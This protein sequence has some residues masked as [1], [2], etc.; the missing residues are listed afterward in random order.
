M[1]SRRSK[2]DDWDSGSSNS[3]VNAVKNH[4]SVD[5][6]SPAIVLDEDCALSK[7]LSSSLMGRI[8][9]FASLTNLKNALMNEGFVDLNL[10]VLEIRQASFDINPD[11]RIVWVEIEGVPLKL[12]TLNTFKRIVTRW[13]N[14][15]DTNDSDG[16]LYWIRA[17]EVPGWTPDLVEDSDE[18]ELSDDDSLEEGMKNLESENDCSNSFEV[19]DT[20]FE[21]EGG[22]KKD[23]SVDPFGLYPLLNKKTKDQKHKESG[24]NSSPKFPP[25]FTPNNDNDDTGD[26][27][28]VNDFEEEKL[29]ED[30]GDS[31]NSNLKENVDESA[32]FGRF[33]KSVAPSLAQKAKKD[34]AKELCVKNKVNFLAIQ[35]TKME[36][37]DL[38][39]VRRCWG[40]STF[41]HL[42]SNSWQGEVV[43]MGDFNEVRVKS[44]RFGTNF[45]VLGANIFNSFINS[46]GLE[47][48]HLG[49]SAFTCRNHFG[50]DSL[51]I[52]I[53]RF[54]FESPA[55]DYGPV[56][57]R[58]FHH[59]IHLEGFNDFVTSTWNSAPS[60]D[61]NGMRNLAGKLK[62]LKA[63]IKI[64]IKDNKSETVSTIANL[65]KELNQLDAV[66]DK[67]TGTEVEAEKRMEVLAALRNIDHIH[68]M[69]LAQKAKIK[70]SI[71][72]DENS[73]FFHG[74]LNKKRNQMNIRGIT[75]DGVW[76]EQPNDVKQEFL[77]H[78]QDRFAKPSE[79]RANIDMRFPKTISEDQSQDLEREV[80]KQEIKT[81]VWGCGTDKSPGP[82]GFS[83]GFYRHFWP[84][85]EHDVY[86]AVNHF[87]IHGEIPP[88]CN[89]SFIALI[90]KV[91]DANLVKDFRPI[92]LI[93]SIY[94]I[95]AKIL[96]NRLV[97]VLG[98]I[99]NEVQS[100]FIA[101]RQML[102]GPFILNEILQWC[103]KK[104]KKTLIF[105]VDFEKAFDSIRWDFLDDV[106]KEFGFRCKWRNWIQSCL[107]SSKGSIL[108]NGCPTNEFQF[109]KGLKQGDPLSPFLFILVMESLHLSFQRIV[110]AGMF[111]G[112]VL[113]QSLCL[114]HMFYAD[115]AIFLGEWSDGNIST[116]IHVLKCFF[117]ASGL[118][119][120]LNKS[121]IMGINVESAQVIQAAAKLGCLVLK[122]PFYYLGTRVGGSMTR[123]QAWQEIV[124]KV[125]SRLSK[126]K[127]KTL[128]I[129]GRLTLLKS[130]LGS[131]PVFH[132]SI[133]KVPSKVLHILESIRSHFFNGHDPGS[134]KA[135]WVKWNNVLTDKKRG[136]L[137]VSSLFA[138][139][140]GLMIKWVWKFLSQKDSLWTKVIVAIHGVGGKIHSE[141]TST[142]KS[143]WLSI[144]SEVRSL[145]RK[146]MYVF[147]Y[148][149]HK[150]GNGESTKF[151]L[152]HWHTRGIFKDIFPRLYA[153]ES[154]KDVTVS[155]KIGDTSLVC[156]FRRIPRGG[157]EQNQFDS[158]VEL[159][160]S[161]TIVPS[162]DR[163]NWNL[164]STGI[165]SVASARRRIDEICLPNIGEETRWVKCVPIKIN[166]LAWKIKTDAL[167]T[168]FNISRRGIDIQDMSC[169]IC[170]NAIESTDHLFFRCGLVRDIANKVLSWWNLD[171]ANL[172]SYAEWKSWLVSI[173]MDSKLKK[174]FEGVWY[175]IWW[176]VWI[177]R[178]KLLFDERKPSKSMLIDNVIASSFYW[179][180]YRSKASFGWNE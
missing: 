124:E 73:N 18:E 87:F 52:T 119:I 83:F 136:G 43:I 96:S 160:R 68:S 19:P 6:D 38:F 65:K 148:L 122:C 90:P 151:W 78:F 176:Y 159:V 88:G 25:G 67:G 134:K 127:S 172:N 125:K 74:I 4:K 170:D 58:F 110:N 60:V 40:N 86:M 147:D 104:K 30:D 92:S 82:D 31:N 137:G 163:W 80:S 47:E 97:N 3:Y 166:V 120:N 129:G 22:S 34:W 158:L 62:F 51:S 26:K 131:I 5:H 89:S 123:V 76:K 99:V 32:S 135:S 143:C 28:S 44:D 54:F 36:E 154:S 23:S 94:K 173:R 42:H 16:N 116:L 130:V 171:H 10:L 14:L 157:I 111:K 50:P 101:E 175:S 46:T 141:W 59:W 106:L 102:D 145:Q 150:M 174:M 45:N 71:E 9:E 117:H 132:M 156:S 35:E 7:D 155:S 37:I 133:F 81:A 1:G 72:G 64:W 169:P 108:V 13:G 48:V 177:Y 8:K 152:D 167:P 162:A 138:L 140:R 39:S 29:N 17:K 56:P 109:Y 27:K 114:S 79:R 100:A 91:P 115:D 146:G 103:T 178:N 164:E 21:N 66:I 77:S 12:W 168:R 70:W 57:F 11:G 33:K 95:I 98:D 153:L 105:K 85:I 165:F 69:D 2:E 113:D 24:T 118:K 128:S 149:T 107:T 63:H 139:N 144:L 55:H 15:I 142:G 84:V 53:D 41:E 126:W 112:I 179:C 93:G 49:G 20:V 121:K 180:K 161:V 75:I 61:S